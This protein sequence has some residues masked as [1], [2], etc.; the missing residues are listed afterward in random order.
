MRILTDSL[1]FLSEIWSIV[2]ARLAT[3]A[4][5]V[6]WW[7]E[8]VRLFQHARFGWRRP[9][10]RGMANEVVA[11]RWDEPSLLKLFGVK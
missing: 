9:F 7:T 1:L 10:G 8:L 3:D 5:W 6:R 2:V 4:R 11:N